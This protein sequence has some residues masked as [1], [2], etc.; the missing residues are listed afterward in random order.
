VGAARLSRADAAG[1]RRGGRGI[2]RADG[3]VAGG[4]ATDAVRAE[5]A[6]A[7]AEV[8]ELARHTHLITTCA[9]N[10]RKL[11]EEI[12]EQ[13]GEP[14]ARL[15]NRHGE[16]LR[17]FGL[18]PVHGN[19]DEVARAIAAN[20]L[21]DALLGMLLEWHMHAKYAWE[22]RKQHPEILADD[23]AAD[24]D[25]KDHLEQVIRSARHL[26]GGAYA[27]WQDLLDRKNVPGLVAFARS[28]DGLSFRSTLVNALGRD[29]KAARQLSAC[30]D[31]LRA[32]VE[33]YP[34]DVWLRSDLA[35]ACLNVPKPERPEA[36]RQ[37]SAAST[38]YPDCAVFHWRIAEC[39]FALGASD[40]A[41]AALKRAV[42][43][44]PRMAP[45][46]E[47]LKAALNSNLDWLQ[48]K[49]ERVSSMDGGPLRKAA[50]TV[51]EI[52]GNK[53]T[54]TWYDGKG[55]V[56]RSHSVAIQLDHTTSKALTYSDMEILQ[57][58]NRGEKVSGKGTYLY[59]LSGDTFY[60]V[61][62]VL[63]TI[64]TAPPTFAIWKRKREK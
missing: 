56:L 34:H 29:L 16:A 42:A 52:R 25:V 33:R 26:S 4:S 39:Y 2:G 3:F 57:G 51:K 8:S 50:R 41:G 45:S 35:E 40:A 37:L 62:H 36:L 10:Q 22:M 21:R 58:P 11:V 53:E 47:S 1:D 63:D 17:Q 14:R 28:P 38:L 19:G 20:R 59:V 24:P 31:F 27:R 9:A 7:R 48:G 32:A 46:A 54:V 5:L 12:N 23:L 13:M 15:A 55:N 43:L 30:R 18:D 6:A 49:W 64:D 60:E 61:N 44:S